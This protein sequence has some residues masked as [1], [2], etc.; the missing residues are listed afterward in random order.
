MEY[1]ERRKQ[2]AKDAVVRLHQIQF[3]RETVFSLSSAGLSQYEIARRLHVSQPLI[4]A[5]LQYLR[6]QFREAL[7]KHI[8]LELP[9]IYAQSMHGIS[10]IIQQ[11]YTIYNSPDVPAQIKLHALSLISDCHE[12]KFNLASSGAVIEQ[13]IAFVENSKK[14]LQRIIT[15]VPKEQ[16]RTML[17]EELELGDDESSRRDESS[18]VDFKDGGVVTGVNDPKS[19]GIDN[20]SVTTSIESLEEQKIDEGSFSLADPNNNK[21][22]ATTPP[23]DNENIEEDT[24][25]TTNTVF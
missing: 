21:T 4:N 20:N 6:M 7:K 22:T 25:D 11:A 15:A 19:N 13:G 5:D 17:H 9:L 2:H 24:C 23:D 1:E 3:R 8:D 16:V 12:Q 18:A 14:H 10:Q